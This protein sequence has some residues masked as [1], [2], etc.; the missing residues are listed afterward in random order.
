[1]RN[2]IYSTAFSIIVLFLD[3]C[4]HVYL[5]AASDENPLIMWPVVPGHYVHIH[6]S[7][8]ARCLRIFST[9][10]DIHITLSPIGSINPYV[11]AQITN[12]YFYI[13]TYGRVVDLCGQGNA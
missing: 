12:Q 7:N 3:L 4:V 11:Y 6:Q 13:P 1:V 5:V 9:E 2:G 8:Y 10:F